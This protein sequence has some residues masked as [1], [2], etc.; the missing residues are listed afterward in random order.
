MGNIIPLWNNASNTENSPYLVVKL[1]KEKK[2]EK[3]S[4]KKMQTTWT[5]DMVYLQFHCKLGRCILEHTLFSSY[6]LHWDVVEDKFQ[7]VHWAQSHL[8]DAATESG[9]PY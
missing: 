3:K 9:Y 8:G 4:G 5:D 2:I 6:E 7:H 1:K